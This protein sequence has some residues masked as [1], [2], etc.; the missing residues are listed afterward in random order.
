MSEIIY[1]AII[2]SRIIIAAYGD[3][4]SINENDIIKLLPTN[5]KSEQKITSGKIYSYITTPGLFFACVGPQN[6][7]KQKQL[8]FLDTLSR[9]W[10][11][12]FGQISTNATS[13]SLDSILAKNFA[14]LFDECNRPQSKTADMHRRLDGTE[15][16]LNQTVS[17]AF[18]RGG[19]LSSLS[20]KSENMMAT[21]EEFRAQAANL[22]WRMRCSYIKSW[23]TWIIIAIL[24]L[25]IVLSWFCGG[26]K[27]PR[28]L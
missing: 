3:G 6:A 27:L 1:C 11:A 10:A 21:S 9:R 22:K 12:S 17:Q 14:P 25:Y 19:E 24:C 2:R 13:H 26:Y 7:D 4:S 28:C 18:V 23:V 5:S 16:I 20:E 8:L 15:Q